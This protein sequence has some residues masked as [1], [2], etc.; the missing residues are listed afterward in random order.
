V[1]LKMVENGGFRLIE[2]TACHFS[3]APTPHVVY[4]SK[5]VESRHDLVGDAFVLNESGE[6]IDK[7][8]HQPRQAGT[9]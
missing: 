3:R 8:F 5:G 2:V 6:T 4:T 9:K 7:F 1:I